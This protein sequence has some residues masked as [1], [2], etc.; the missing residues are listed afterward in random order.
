MDFLVISHDVRMR[1]TNIH[2][3]HLSIEFGCSF[4]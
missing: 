1:L 3:Q 2:Q 4:E